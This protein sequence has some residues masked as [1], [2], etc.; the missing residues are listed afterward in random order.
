[1]DAGPHGTGAASLT[2]LAVRLDVPPGGG[3]A[4]PVPTLFAASGR[5]GSWFSTTWPA[6]TG[7]MSQ[8]RD[9]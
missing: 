7:L 1:V 9:L 4:T 8:R 5:T 2:E 3:A 6:T